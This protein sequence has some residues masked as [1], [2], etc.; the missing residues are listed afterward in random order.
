[1]INGTVATS[2]MEQYAPQNRL[3][4]LKEPIPP[5]F[6]VSSQFTFKTF[7]FPNVGSHGPRLINTGVQATIDIIR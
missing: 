2:A 4:H 1:M 6:P 3:P 7:Q 5:Q